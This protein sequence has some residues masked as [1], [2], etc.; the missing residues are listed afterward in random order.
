[1]PNANRVKT[2]SAHSKITHKRIWLVFIS[3]VVAVAIALVALSQRG[4]Y[5]ELG[6]MRF[7]A[8]VVDTDETR[9]LGL[10][11]RDSLAQDAAMLFVFETPK[12]QCIWMKGMRFDIDIL[13]FDSS[14]RL[15][16]QKHRVS[17]Q[18]YP[19][20]FCVDNAQYVVELAT[21]TAQTLGLEQGDTF[22][23]QGR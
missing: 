19:R 17:P 8:E 9:L 18:T 10:S 22:V 6:G 13:W 23:L 4:S 7:R 14:Q 21:G 15:V 11:G 20:S 1:M 5:L 12:T 16:S 3:I 2:A